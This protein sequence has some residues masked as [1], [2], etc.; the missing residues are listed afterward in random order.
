[1]NKKT[2]GI[3][4][5]VITVAILVVLGV[6]FLL[7]KNS[8]TN[9]NIEGNLEDIMSK[10]Y[11]GIPENEL[12]SSLTTF[13]MTE[14]VEYYLGTSDIDFAE[15]VVSEPMMSSIAHSIVL[16]RLNDG[17]N[18]EETMQKIKENVNPRKWICVG[19]EDEN[20]RVLNRGNVILLIMTDN[21]TDIIENNFKNL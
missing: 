8:Q 6:I 14:N 1:M 20:V 7:P 12:P 19:V 13:P 21:N 18:T 10:L 4:A 15:A 3:I 11:E 2:I 16:V 9:G 5:I 17:A